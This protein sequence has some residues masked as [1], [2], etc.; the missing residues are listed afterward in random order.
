MVELVQEK[1]ESN[2]FRQ[3]MKTFT[4]SMNDQA[5]S[6]IDHIWVNC[7]RKVVNHFNKIRSC[8]DHNVVG[9]NVNKK[10]IRTGGQNMIRRKWMNF[11]KNQIP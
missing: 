7:E 11:N 3:L 9:V 5:D 8:S 6:I 1:I 10:D 2:G 4:R